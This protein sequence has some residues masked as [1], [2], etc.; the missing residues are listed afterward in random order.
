[1]SVVTAT[2]EAL[3]ELPLVRVVL[4]TYTPKIS[5]GSF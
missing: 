5:P 3:L 4:L 2:Q 1:M